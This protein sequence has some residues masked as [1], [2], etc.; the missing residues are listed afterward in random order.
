MEILYR[1]GD[2]ET[3]I[4]VWEK[5]VSKTPL[6]RLPLPFHISPVETGDIIHDAYSQTTPF[7]TVRLRVLDATLIET[8]PERVQSCRLVKSPGFEE[9]WA[10]V[11][12][13]NGSYVDDIGRRVSVRQKVEDGINEVDDIEWAAYNAARFSLAICGAMV[14][15][16]LI[17]GRFRI[18]PLMVW[19]LFLDR[20]LE[21]SD[22]K[23]KNLIL[24]EM[25]RMKA[26]TDDKMTI[27]QPPNS[28]LYPPLP[29]EPLA[30]RLVVL[31]PSTKRYSDIIC[32][33]C[34]GILGR[35][36]YEALSYVW[37]DA[38]R[39]RSIT[40]NDEPFEATENLEKALRNL[41]S[42]DHPRVL[43]IDSMCIN[44][45]EVNER[46]AQVRKMDLIYSRSQRVIVWLGPESGDSSLAMEWFQCT[47]ADFTDMTTFFEDLMR[48][49]PRLYETGRKVLDVTPRHMLYASSL[50][51]AQNHLLQRTWFRRIWCVQEF[52]LGQHVVF[53]CG[54][55]IIASEDFERYIIELSVLIGKVP[56]FDDSDDKV[57][58]FRHLT[59]DIGRFISWKTRL[60]DP[61]VS[62]LSLLADF[63]TW[64]SSDPRDKVF[65]LY[66]I[67]PKDNP[68]RDV[69]KP[70][71]HLTTS[72]TY[73]KVAVYFLKQYRNLDILSIATQPT[74]LG[75]FITVYHYLPSWVPDWRD[76]QRF[77]IDRICRPVAFY[78]RYR[79]PSYFDN[80]Y[81]YNASSHHGHTRID[82]LDHDQVL[83][84][85]GISVGTI[86][87]IGSIC[88]GFNHSLKDFQR[89]ISEWKEIAGVSE[90]H[91]YKFSDQPVY[92]AWWR[93][94]LGDAQI[95]DWG[96]EKGLRYRLP[97]KDVKLDGLDSFP[98]S[99]QDEFRAIQEVMHMT[100]LMC[101]R[102]F[103]KT[104]TGLFGLAAA[105]AE[106]GDHVVVLFGGR[107]PFILRKFRKYYHVVGER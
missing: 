68:D 84:L 35:D 97:A 38:S 59:L 10:V 5:A 9:R 16:T 85:D 4:S 19:R 76:G 93:T 75:G 31:L 73:V 94:I 25:I 51:A 42:R 86:E 55:N 47:S 83:V 91:R 105:S 81:I 15:G 56:E 96:I 66:G 44:Q 20:A 80:I 23:M 65:G 37:G 17:D 41:R 95:D 29:E 63:S 77:P 58:K 27:L 36:K 2:T 62:V 78:R 89:I 98:P 30:I 7:L 72:E 101:G 88:E 57:S 67:V 11:L 3:L 18:P 45:N 14:N 71:Y 104:S 40:M 21:A 26:Q 6:S 24:S 49:E 54:Q 107:C 64:A 74:E 50:L 43:W 60:R 48:L 34:T 32:R 92:E 100:P 106:K 33:L 52:I 102:K 79:D 99:S 13:D 8:P 103:F 90:E 87:A 39:K 22:D 28:Y 82:I 53:Q 1:V 12:N 70:D 61:R 69:L 46:N